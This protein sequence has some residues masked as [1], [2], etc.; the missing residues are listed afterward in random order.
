MDFSIRDTTNETI[1]SVKGQNLGSAIRQLEN[2][3]EQ[4]YGIKG[5]SAFDYK[6]Y[7]KRKKKKE[8]VLKF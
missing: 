1:F 4:K 5:F 7:P 3:L 6:G 8:D 2:F